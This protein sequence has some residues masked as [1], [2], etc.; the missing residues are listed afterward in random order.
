MT[1]VMAA[2]WL[3]AARLGPVPFSYRLPLSGFSPAW[4]GVPWAAFGVAV[5]FQLAAPFM[6]RRSRLRED[7][8][9]AL[10]L[11]LLGD[12]IAFARE[13]A[14]HARRTGEPLCPARSYAALAYLS[15]PA[16][17]RIKR[18]LAYGR[19]QPAPSLTPTGAGERGVIDR[20]RNA[21]LAGGWAWGIT[22]AWVLGVLHQ[23]GMIH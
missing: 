18:R 14:A 15:P 13:V 4:Q 12:G 21:V 16:G 17:D 22:L 7:A 8:A 3:V 10:V 11:Q 20:H 19:R 1:A 5:T 2:A 9:D 6:H 23:G